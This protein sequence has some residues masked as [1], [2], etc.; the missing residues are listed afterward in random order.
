MHLSDADLAAALDPSGGGTTGHAARAHAASCET[1][2]SAIET[3]QTADREVGDLLRLLDHPAPSID[4]TFLETR[5]LLFDRGHVTNGAMERATN[6]A[7]ERATDA[8]SRRQLD[9]RR[10]T[11]ASMRSAEPSQRSTLTVAV[12]RGAVI[13]A[14]SA[15]VAAA[16]APRSPVRQFIARLTSRPHTSVDR[17]VT[18]AALTSGPPATAAASPRGVAINP[19]GRADL[20]FRSPEPA[21]VVRIL[22]ASGSQVSVTA[23]ADGPTYTVGNGTITVDS[24]GT[25]GVT[26]DVEL[27]SV[28][29][30]PHLSIRVGNR[31]IFARDEN[32]VHT[33]GQPRADG[34]YALSLER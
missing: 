17:P 4:A 11:P 3:A 25:P 28:A 19:S 18:P 8:Q 15:A 12:R 16:A 22:P 9:R 2:M 10:T 24:H 32:G 34:T 33:E 23:S 5:T 31:V 14:L 20:V 6:G 29:T 21:G 27:P 1:C 13:L 26:Y 30:L 7:T